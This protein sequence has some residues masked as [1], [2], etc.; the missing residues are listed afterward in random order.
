M[1]SP[2]KLSNLLKLQL[3]W[4]R[5]ADAKVTALFAVNTAMLGIITALAKSHKVWAISEAVFVALSSIP[6]LVSVVSL[7]FV[8]FPRLDGPRGSSIFFGGIAAQDQER[9]V[10][11]MVN[12]DSESLNRDFAYQIHRNA[13][14]ALAKYKFVKYAFVATFTSLPFW[15]AA[16]YDLYGA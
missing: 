4:V 8:L 6:L 12:N 15:L 5:A 11:N 1:E 9:Y 16:I 10:E 13:E 7:A 14:I 2:E 3:E